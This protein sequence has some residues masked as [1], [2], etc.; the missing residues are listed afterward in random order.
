MGLRQIH[1]HLLPFALASLNLSRIIICRYG[2]RSQ[3]SSPTGSSTLVSSFPVNMSGRINIL[4]VSRSSAAD[5][6]ARWLKPSKSPIRGRDLRWSAAK[7]GRSVRSLP[8]GT[9]TPPPLAARRPRRKTPGQMGL[10]P[11]LV[12]CYY[13]LNVLIIS[14]LPKQ[15][16]YIERL[17]CQRIGSRWFG[18][19][20]R[21]SAAS[22]RS[23]WGRWGGAGEKASTAAAR[24]WPP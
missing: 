24:Q 17:I 12:S 5:E 15:T 2:G 19:S 13:L 11:L 4:F 7:R 1:L 6:V 16:C 22:R 14:Q 8:S 18:S 23:D 3:P 9:S 10:L 21:T 20:Q